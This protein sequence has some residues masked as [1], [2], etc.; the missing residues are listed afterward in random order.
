MG[1]WFGKKTFATLLD[2]AAERR[3]PREA[4]YYEGRRWSFAELRAEADAVARGLIGLGIKPGDKATLWMPNR[5]EW[6][7]VFFALS[8]IGAII[9]PANT[10]FRA[11]DIDNAALEH[12]TPAC[13]FSHL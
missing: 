7:Y 3:G 1:D 11:A 4:L 5:P 8:R 12:R 9:V 2:E 13:W 6:I 10:R